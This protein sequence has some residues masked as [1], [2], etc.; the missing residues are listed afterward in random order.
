MISNAP[1]R[2]PLAYAGAAGGKMFYRHVIPS[3]PI[4]TTVRDGR[5]SSVPYYT[6]DCS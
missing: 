1:N 2:L 4:T 3:Q 5:I 6:T